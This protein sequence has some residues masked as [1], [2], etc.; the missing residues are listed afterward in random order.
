MEVQTVRRRSADLGRGVSNNAAED[1]RGGPQL[2][3]AIQRDGHVEAPP[4]VVAEVPIVKRADILL[5][6][7]PVP[8]DGRDDGVHDKG[9]HPPS[10]GAPVKR[11]VPGTAHPP[12][13][14]DGG[15]AEEV[16]KAEERRISGGAGW[17]TRTVIR[18]KDGEGRFFFC[19]GEE[20]T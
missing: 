17:P 3:E 20:F 10:E 16:P 19:S 9:R 1:R 6:P 13:S 7:G 12:D 4:P 2:D 5:S 14:P 11:L 18:E 8:L 15:D